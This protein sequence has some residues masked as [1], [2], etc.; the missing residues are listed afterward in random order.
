[1]KN[2][3][4]KVKAEPTVCGGGPSDTHVSALQVNTSPLNWAWK[5][6]RSQC[7]SRHMGMGVG[8]FH[9]LS[10]LAVCKSSS[11]QSAASPFSTC[12][13]MPWCG[14]STISSSFPLTNQNSAEWRG[15]GECGNS[16]PSRISWLSFHVLIEPMSAYS[17]RSHCW[18][19]IGTVMAPTV[20]MFR[21][22]ALLKVSSPQFLPGSQ[23]VSM[24]I[25]CTMHLMSSSYWHP[26]AKWAQH[27]RVEVLGEGMQKWLLFP[28]ASGLLMRLFAFEVTV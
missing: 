13:R 1:M 22:P 18:P 6:T 3:R 4:N 9:A 17:L 20:W 14:T 19:S 21:Q 15:G 27:Q 25:K 8:G 28:F 26:S 12:S 10:L 5:H 2:K 7:Y 11:P 24:A 16:V 23:K